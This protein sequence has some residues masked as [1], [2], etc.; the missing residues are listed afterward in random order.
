MRHLSISTIDIC[1]GKFHYKLRFVIR[2]TQTKPVKNHKFQE[3]SF[4]RKTRRRLSNSKIFCKKT[5][6][7]TSTTVSSPVLALRIELLHFSDGSN[8]CFLFSR[9]GNYARRQWGYA[10]DGRG[11]RCQPGIGKRGRYARDFSEESE[12][13]LSFGWKKTRLQHKKFPHPAAFANRRKQTHF[14]KKRG[15]R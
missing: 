6:T 9:L 15:N 14:R 3:T 8:D 10:L 1:A 13:P 12:K 5:R 2:L 4:E 7:H 11:H